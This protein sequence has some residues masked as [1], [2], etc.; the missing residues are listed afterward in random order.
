MFYGVH[1][2]IVIIINVFHQAARLPDGSMRFSQE[3]QPLSQPLS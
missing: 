2:V 1:S 3:E